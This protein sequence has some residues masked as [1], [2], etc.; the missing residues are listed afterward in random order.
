MK[1]IYI[2][3]LTFFVPLATLAQKDYGLGSTAD[4]AGLPKSESIESQVGFVL[5]GA[6]SITGLLFLGL[7]V[8]GGFK[9]LLSQGD[10]EAYNKGKDTIVWAVVGL[11][12]LTLAYAHTRYVFQ[13]FVPTTSA[14]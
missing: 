11:F 13:Q 9:I 3:V 1:K 8:Y 4:A 2:A 14:L 10:S 7:A 5:N 12:V 6:L